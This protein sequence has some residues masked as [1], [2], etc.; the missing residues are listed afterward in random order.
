MTSKFY[1]YFQ[2]VEMEAKVKGKN[3]YR[4][5]HC[6]QHKVTSWTFYGLRLTHMVKMLQ[7][8]HQWCPGYYLSNGQW[9][10]INIRRLQSSRKRWQV[11]RSV[12]LLQM[13]RKMKEMKSNSKQKN[14]K[15]W[16]I[17][18]PWRTFSGLSVKLTLT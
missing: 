6:H 18:R 14:K 17:Y 4:C 16:P 12:H 3:D 2:Q 1:A 15:N 8:K 10:R 13:R 7:W 9:T 5:Y 11:F